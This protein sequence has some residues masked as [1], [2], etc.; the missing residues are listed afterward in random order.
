MTS[1]LRLG[2]INFINVIPVHRHLASDPAFV[3]VPAVPS[4][5]NRMTAAGEL[6]LSAVSS[7]EYAQRH[8]DYLLLPDL[9]LSSRGPVASVL[10]LS[11]EP[12]SA[13]AGREIEA[14]FESD[15]SVALLRLL[16]RRLWGVDCAL[17]GE[18]QARQNPAAVLRI[19]NRAL[20][21][22]ASGRWPLVWDLGRVW[23]EWTGLPFVYALWVVRRE[24]A[25][26]RGAE[27]A[28]LHRA[29][30]AA[31][32]QGLADREGCARQAAESLGGEPKDR[33]S[34]V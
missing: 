6:D 19:G 17:V 11:R 18:G 3:E 30:L 22:A 12:M 16:L 25:D 28:R 23:W 24:V 14:P 26:R 21:E 1:P 10:L 33:K 4:A 2:R 15:T 34:V 5:L 31:R 9:G 8:R 27:V 13:W 20:S 7:V 29:L 32:D